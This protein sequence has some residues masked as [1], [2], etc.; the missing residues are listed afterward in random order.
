MFCCGRAGTPARAKE[1]LIS[2]QTG[3][4]VHEAKF[5]LEDSERQWAW[6]MRSDDFS[7]RG[8]R[9][10]TVNEPDTASHMT[11]RLSY[12]Q[13]LTEVLDHLFRTYM[14]IRLT[15]QFAEEVANMAG[16]LDLKASEA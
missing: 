7:L 12:I 11:K 6:T 8:L 10:P 15:P 13:I 1:A 4:L 14:S 9:V 16:W 3:K 2:L 5:R